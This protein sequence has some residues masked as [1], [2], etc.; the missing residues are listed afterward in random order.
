MVIIRRITPFLGALLLAGLFSALLLQQQLWQWWVAGIAAVTVGSMLY[1][2]R[3]NVFS[4]SFWTGL[5]PVAAFTAGGVGLLFFLDRPV[6]QWT[7]AAVCVVVYMVYAENVFTFHYQQQ[8][9]TSLSLP[10]MSLYLYTIA[11]FSLFSFFYALHLIRAMP[12]WGI[13]VAG[14]VFPTIMMLQLMR[15]YKVWEPGQIASVILIALVIT[16]LVWVLQFWPTSYYING[17]IIAVALYCIPSLFLLKLRDTL[18][19]RT[20]VQY[21]VISVAAL[22]SVLSTTQWT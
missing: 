17:T 18:T 1:M 13:I 3:W 6:Y 16:E 21:L 2:H 19:R 22:A 10:Q 8:R 5:L 7:F 11:G 12:L 14:V 4:V 20:V 9:Y 15:G